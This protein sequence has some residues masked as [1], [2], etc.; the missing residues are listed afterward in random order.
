MTRP[1]NGPMRLALVSQEYP[2]ETDHGGIATQARLKAHGLTR[3]GH[4]VTVVSCSVDGQ[5]GEWTGPAGIRVI[6]VVPDESVSQDTEPGR[7]RAWSAAAAAELDRLHAESPL[8]LVEFPEWAAEGH[9]WLT[10][11]GDGDRDRPVVGRD[12]RPA[13]VVHVHGPLV[14]F[15][16]ALGWPERDSDLYREG[17]AMEGECL[18]RADAVYAS[19]RASAG[20]VAR[21]HGLDAGAIPVLHAGV[22]LERFTPG[23]AKAPDP[24]IIFVGKVARSKGAD[25]L[26]EAA[27]ALAPRLPGLTVELVGRGEPELVEELARRAR[28]AGYPDLVRPAGFVPRETLPDRL[29]R[30]WVLAAPSRYEGGPGFV[31]LEAMACGLPVVAGAEGGM[32]EAFEAGAQG[33]LVPPGDA[34]A[35]AAALEPLL[36]DRALR[37]GMGAAA[38]RHVEATAGTAA[39][40]ARIEALYREVVAAGAAPSTAGAAR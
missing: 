16:H 38:R 36:A 20:W 5:R 18:R 4:H 34:P 29:G 40:V 30:A 24:T 26:V 12:R 8:D 2:P 14:M 21:H 32:G 31:L 35:L 6:R 33:L 19:S 27:L 13:T 9:A 37:E 1:P 28:A 23:G 25:T 10:G 3:R 15:A 17:A 39:C 7:W 22:E 11:R